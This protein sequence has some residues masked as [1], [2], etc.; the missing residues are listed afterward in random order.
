M[1]C[2][3]AMTR[4]DITRYRINVPRSILRSD[5]AIR[6]LSRRPMGP[7]RQSARSSRRVRLTVEDSSEDEEHVPLRRGKGRRRRYRISSSPLPPPG[8]PHVPSTSINAGGNISSQRERLDVE[9]VDRMILDVEPPRAR[10]RSIIEVVLPRQRRSRIQ[11]QNISPDS[12]C[13]PK[14]ARF[15][16]YVSESESD[17]EDESMGIDEDELETHRTRSGKFIR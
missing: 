17:E 4:V 15:W 1:A 8:L 10:G 14:N 12:E 5:D 11:Q 3:Q 6:E 13:R 16:V 9:T 2:L 7:D